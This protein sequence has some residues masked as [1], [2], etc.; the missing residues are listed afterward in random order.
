MEYEGVAKALTFK[1]REEAE[2]GL[3]HVTA[4]KL[5]ALFTHDVDFPDVPNLI[6]AYGKRASEIASKHT[7]SGTSRQGIFVEHVGLDAT[8]IWA[9]ATSGKGAI[10]IHLLACILAYI[11]KAPEAISIWMEIVELRKDIL[12]SRIQSQVFQP[13]ELAAARISISRDQLAKWDASARYSPISYLPLQ[14]LY[15]LQV[16]GPK[17]RYLVPESTET[18]KAHHPRFRYDPSLQS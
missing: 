9:A 11:F 15:V 14:C 1:R 17:C 6:A 4:R 5:T 13:W 12:Q 2:D 7:R 18:S 8:S 3:S 16:L 10:P